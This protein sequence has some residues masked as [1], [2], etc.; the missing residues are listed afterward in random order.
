MPVLKGL[1]RSVGSQAIASL[2]R[3]LAG[4]DAGNTIILA[5]AC[6]VHFLSLRDKIM[7]MSTA[8]V[9]QDPLDDFLSSPLIES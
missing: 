9:A 4:R 5:F 6:R 3:V 1:I 7:A 2:G 8:S